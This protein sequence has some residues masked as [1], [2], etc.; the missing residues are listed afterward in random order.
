MKTQRDLAHNFL[1]H[2]RNIVTLFIVLVITY[3]VA[4]SPVESSTST[5]N[6]KSSALKGISTA[7]KSVTKLH[8]ELKTVIPTKTQQLTLSGCVN[9]KYLN[10]RTGPSDQYSKNGFLENGDCETFIERN[11]ENTWVKFS[12]GWLILK[13]VDLQG[14]V[15][16]LPVAENIPTEDVKKLSTNPT[17]VQSVST[18]IPLP[19]PTLKSKPTPTPKPKK[20]NCDPS[21]PSVCIKPRPPDLDCKDIP[22]RRFTVLQPDPHNFDGDFDGIGCEW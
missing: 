3:T 11:V 8:K 12:K 10:I 18:T 2:P 22:Y 20:S 7:T 4:C 16:G 15:S 6:R 14:S 19:S 21:Y 9:A 1:E 5:N 13:Y 17:L